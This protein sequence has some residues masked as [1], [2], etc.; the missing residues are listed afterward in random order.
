MICS[1]MV[2]V[3][4]GVKQGSV[5]FVE[6][7]LS[8]GLQSL[9]CYIRQDLFIYAIEALVKLNKVS[10]IAIMHEYAYLGKDKFFH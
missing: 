7:H 3:G 8:Q 9:P 2:V 4:R 5:R 6:D 1:D 10:I